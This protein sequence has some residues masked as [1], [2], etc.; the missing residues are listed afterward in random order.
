MTAIDR[1]LA[2]E[3]SASCQLDAGRADFYALLGR[4]LVAAPDDRLLALLAGLAVDGATPLGAALAAL[5]AAAAGSRAEAV[6]DEYHALLVGLPRGEL[7]PYASH[8]LTGF[9]NDKPLAR[10]RS[11][12]AA[13]GIEARPDRC[14]P[15]DHAGS[16]CEMMAGLI[17]G[18]FGAAAAATQRDFFQAH[19][20][21]W[22][23]RFFSDLETAPSAR[24]YRAVGALG[25]IF[26]DIER[27]AFS[28]A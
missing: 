27:Q 16:L 6:A 26:T 22:A 3:P 9:L 20:A 24:F 10:L 4:L 25:R 11:D 8:Y 13:L 2:A 21:P 19:L 18:A 12:M 23:E 1:H 5:A 17:S 28:L 14:E 15:E 7:L